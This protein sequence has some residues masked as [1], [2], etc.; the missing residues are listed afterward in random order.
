MVRKCTLIP[1]AFSNECVHESDDGVYNYA[2]ILCDYGALNLEFRDSWA[3][4]D[5][6]HTY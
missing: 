4:D 3:E 1:E 2:H 6:E 5:G